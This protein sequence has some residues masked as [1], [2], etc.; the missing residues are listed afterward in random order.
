[1]GTGSDMNTDLMI[2]VNH[3]RFRSGFHFHS[4]AFE[5]GSPQGCHHVLMRNERPSDSCRHLGRNQARARGQLRLPNYSSKSQF[6]FPT[7]ETSPS[8]ECA[9]PM[10]RDRSSQ[11][12]R[13]EVDH[14]SGCFY[15]LRSTMT[16]RSNRNASPLFT[17]A[18]HD[19]S[20]SIAAC[21]AKWVRNQA[22]ATG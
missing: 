16:A 17:R 13:S 4:N 8:V 20:S 22:S 14:P 21:G 12:N 7:S 19:P 3:D 2:H 11:Q 9:A 1:M 6:T 10:T 18:I 5:K 15:L